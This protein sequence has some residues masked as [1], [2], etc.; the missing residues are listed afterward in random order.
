MKM[1][2][3]ELPQDNLGKLRQIQHHTNVA[4]SLVATVAA[5]QL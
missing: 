1:S 3:K 4:L 2:L 5:V